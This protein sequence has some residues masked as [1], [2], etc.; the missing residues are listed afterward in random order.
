MDNLKNILFIRSD[1]F[2]EFLLN[3]PAIKLV[4]L[5]YPKSKILVL[6]KKEN[7][8]L[9]KGLDFVDCFLEYGE[10]EFSGYSVIFRLAKLFR[11]EQIDCV[12]CLNP[13]K[14]FHLASFLARVRLRLGYNR[15]WP[16]CLNKKIEDKKFLADKHEVEYNIDLV[17]LICKDAFIPEI[18]LPIDSRDSL[19]F[20]KEAI[21]VNKDYI[22]IHPF[23]SN[24]AKEIEHMFWK[25][26][27]A[28]IKKKCNRDILVIGGPQEKEESIDFAKQINA[29]N[30]TGRLSMRNLAAL[31]K[32]N[33]AV[34][35]GL[36][37]GPMHL[38]A[39]LKK[40]VVGLFTVSSPKRW[41]PFSS[42]S[43]VIRIHSTE[44]LM[45]QIE[46]IVKF[47]CSNLE[48]KI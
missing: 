27:A 32:Y 19:A 18:E 47:T 5:N 15:K 33:C 21:D 43:L 7:I 23:T 12:I 38:A 40:P 3:L 13:K 1:R 14:E 6:A 41:G 17:K 8:E 36:D 25:S 39:L 34:F 11:K 29:K 28:E 22:V 24:P 4:R 45:R 37:S 48:N 46:D 42:D 16:W 20:L 9:I 44:S 10:A 31:L 35:I 30:V 26:L 2:G